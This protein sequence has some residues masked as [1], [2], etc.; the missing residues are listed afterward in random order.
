MS[1]MT[2]LYNGD[3]RTEGTHL[4]SGNKIITDAPLDNNGKGEAYSPT[5]LV[6]AALASCI[7]TTLGI[8]AN[9]ENL[10]IVNMKAE[11]TKVMVSD[12]R[13]ISEIIIDITLPESTVLKLSDKHKTILKRAAHSC[14][15]ALSLHPDIKQNFHFNF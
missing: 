13:R 12:P 9:R 14:P 6:C 7:L 2:A 3:L 10:D 8:L 15:V 1:Q 11:I 4:K 5:D